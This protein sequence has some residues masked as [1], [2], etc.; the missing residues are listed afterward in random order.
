[1]VTNEGHIKLTDYGLSKM[2]IEEKN[3]LSTFIGTLEYTAPEAI[4][5]HY[6]KQVDLWAIGVLMYELKFKRNPFEITQTE[7]YDTIQ[8]NIEKM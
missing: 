2:I 3:P 8:T 7:N 1:M 5:G 4:K 6:G